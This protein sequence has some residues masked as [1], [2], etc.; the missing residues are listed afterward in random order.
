MARKSTFITLGTQVGIQAIGLVTG[1]LVA[2]F[3]GP[4]GRGELAAIIVWVSLVAYLGNLGLPTAYTYSAARDPSRLRS[5]LGNG[6][7]AMLVQWP[8]LF[9]A[10]LL[11]IYSALSGYEN[12]TRHLAVVYLGLYIPFNLL[13]LYA[14]RTQQ[15]LG[16]FVGFNAVR[17]C[18]PVSY[19]AALGLLAWMERFTVT[20]VL[21]ANLFSN[22]MAFALALSLLLSRAR[23]ATGH[24]WIDLPALK[25]DLRYGLSA[26]LGTLQPF[27]GL[28]IDVLM[29]TLL[30]QP[31]DLGLYMAA[32]AGSGLIRA[33]G[34]A[35]GMVTMP[36]V[37]KHRDRPSQYRKLA[38]IAS[39]TTGLSGATAGVLVL[40]AKPLVD[41]VY[42]AAFDG[43]AGALQILALA[44]LMACINRV[45]A[46]G[47][48]G[49]GQPLTGTAA[50][51]A[52]LVVG[53]P[54]LL[55]LAP[56]HGASG[57]AAAVTLASAAALAVTVWSFFRARPASDESA[58]T[59]PL[60]TV[61]PDKGINRQ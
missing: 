35:L 12:P 14:N 23:E 22:L 51:M 32:L 19:V 59:R 47:L 36:E 4:E 56:P 1:I 44:A 11:V 50:E 60:E 5:L 53:M 10:G 31:D 27:T 18:V 29:L 38:R 28:Q 54:A 24:P 39:F 8:L 34:V 43:A 40:W 21:A 57:A 26:H 16:H 45:L 61:S 33:Q 7:V 58:L 9:A 15:G 41:L 6:L 20:G 48:R 30:L 3:L 52:S 17:L 13:T 2:R 42:G 55:L 46:D 25:R 37:A 49:M